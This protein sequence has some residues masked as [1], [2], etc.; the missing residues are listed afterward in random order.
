[1][2]TPTKNLMQPHEIETIVKTL[3]E[4]G[5]N[6]IRLTGGEPLVRK[7]IRDILKVF[8]QFPVELHMTTN[9]I[10]IDELLPQ[11]IATNFSSIN[12]SLDTLSREKFLKITRRDYFDKVR[13]NI[14]LLLQ[15]ELKVKINVVMMK[16]VNDEELVDFIELTRSNNIDVRFIEFMPFDNN[17]WTSNQVMTYQEIT[18]QL[19]RSYA[20]VPIAGEKHDT[21]KLYSIPGYQGRFGI[22]STLTAPFCSE[23]NR[24]RLTADGKLKN[25]LFSKHETDLLNPLRRSE[26]ILPLIKQNIL[27]KAKGLGG[28]L[29]TD[30]T[31]IQPEVLQNR[32]MISIGG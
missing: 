24:I 9:G 20:F 13:A 19:A 30:F 8:A 11:I 7:D 2:S 28:Q 31:M 18:D 16:G 29:K 15:H 26:A 3:V 10:R 12:I 27:A 6:K 25:C 23:C 5:I 32:S 4:N 22:I 17:K 14:D 21:C 1:A